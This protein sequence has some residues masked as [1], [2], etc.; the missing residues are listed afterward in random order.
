VPGCSC[1]AAEFQPSAAGV[2]KKAEAPTQ[3]GSTTRLSA[4]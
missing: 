2:D 4:Q 1:K 3:P